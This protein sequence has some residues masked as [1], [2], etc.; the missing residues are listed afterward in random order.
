MSETNGK[1]TTAKW[2][3]LGNHIYSDESA[4]SVVYIYQ[5]TDIA[6]MTPF[7]A[8]CFALQLAIN[9]T[10]RIKQSPELRVELKKDFAA[11]LFLGEGIEASERYAPPASKKWVDV[12]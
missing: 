6:K 1:K 5:L 9:I 10:Y 3:V 12:K 7:L 8:L 2:E 4:I 11:A